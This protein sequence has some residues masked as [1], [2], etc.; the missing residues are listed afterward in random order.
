MVEP[1]SLYCALIYAGIYSYVNKLRKSEDKVKNT[2]RISNHDNIER[3]M[4]IRTA[5]EVFKYLNQIKINDTVINSN[6]FSHSISTRR[7][8]NRLVVPTSRNAASQKSFIIQGALTYNLLP[9]ILRILRIF[10]KQ[11]FNFSQF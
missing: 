1:I 7:N 4:K 2:V 10:L 6:Y 9:G 5:T 11:N 3:K 8:G